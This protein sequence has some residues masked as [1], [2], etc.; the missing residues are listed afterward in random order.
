MKVLVTGATGFI[1][2]HLTEQLVKEG[3]T[4]KALTRECSNITLLKSLGVEIVYGD[5]R[6]V[7]AVEIARGCEQAYHLAAVTSLRRQSRLEY[8]TVNVV[9]T[10]NVARAA[11]KAGVGRLVYESTAG[12]YGTIKNPPVDEHIKPN[13]N[14]LYR[15]SK[16]LGEEVI[17]SYHKKE[18]LPVVIAR[19]SSVFGPRSLNWLG[20]FQAIARK[21]FRIIGS[22]E[23]HVH[24]GYVS[25]IVNGLRRCTEVD[26]IERESYSITGGEPIKLKQLLNMIAEELGVSIS[27]TRS[28]EFPFRSFH[29]MSSFVY[30]RFGFELPRAH[31]YEL[32]LENRILDISKAQK[33]LG[34][35]PK[36]SMEEGIRQ[37]VNWY[38]ENGYI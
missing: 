34:Y 28:P 21:H 33:E 7:A 29:S 24:M 5:I 25:D 36:V 26:G 12:V 37:T 22:G 32:F 2:S 35:Y 15:E 27:S 16:L 8:Y 6:D 1:G 3:Y 38:R 4:V 10:E 18:G 31:T 19:L 20:L 9:G 14:T 11:M 17:L 13:P 23:N 30:R